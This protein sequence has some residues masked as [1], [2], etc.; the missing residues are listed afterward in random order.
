MNKKDQNQSLS[1][2]ASN[3]FKKSSDR[4]QNAAA[5]KIIRII[6]GEEAE[7]K[8]DNINWGVDQDLIDQAGLALAN[9]YYFGVIEE[10]DELS[11]M[12]TPIKYFEQNGCCSDQTGPI[13]HLLPVCGELA[14]STWECYDDNVK[15]VVDAAKH[16]QQN[17]FLWSKDFQNFLDSAQTEKIEKAL[18]QN[19]KPSDRPTPKI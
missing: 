9:R 17:G 8:G 13:S 10:D 6:M 16:M 3:S 4:T 12:T 7:S 15:T 11:V 14:E 5:D 18:K 19:S 2:R 1:D